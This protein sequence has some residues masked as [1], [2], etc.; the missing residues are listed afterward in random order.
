MVG[1]RAKTYDNLI[2]KQNAEKEKEKQHR[3]KQ[4]YE[5][6]QIECTICKKF[7]QRKCLDKHQQTKSCQKNGLLLDETQQ[8]LHEEELKEK[9][10]EH[11]KKYYESN[12]EKVISQ[13]SEKIECSVCKSLITRNKMN[14]HQLTDICKKKALLL[15]ITEEEKDIQLKQKKHEYNNRYYGS[16][17]E[18]ILSQHSEKIQCHICNK[19]ICR[20]NMNRH[21][22]S[23]QCKK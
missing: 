13:Q 10:K 9:Q 4:Q 22:E 2:E 5:K 21:Q 19:L 23:T 15:N 12:K 14:R 7:I 20:N 3:I 1:R 6:E 16:N 8:K 17:K 11:C 18:Q